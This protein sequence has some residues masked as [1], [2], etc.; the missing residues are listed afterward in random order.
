MHRANW[1]LV[2]VNSADVHL[3]TTDAS[4]I[5]RCIGLDGCTSWATDVSVTDRCIGQTSDAS[6]NAGYIRHIAI[7]KQPE[8]PLATPLDHPA[9]E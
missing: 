1:H 7:S 5:D 4:V 8:S 6:A 9:T 2:S 3:P